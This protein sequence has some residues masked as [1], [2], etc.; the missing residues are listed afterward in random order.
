MHNCGF[1]GGEFTLNHVFSM[2]ADDYN[3][4]KGFSMMVDGIRI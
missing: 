1:A 2:L 4:T 3:K